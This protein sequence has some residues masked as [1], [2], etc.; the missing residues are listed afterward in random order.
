MADD[1]QQATPGNTGSGNTGGQ[2]QQ[3]D[4]GP[5]ENEMP[6][7]EA[8]DKRIQSGEDRR[9]AETAFGNK[10]GGDSSGG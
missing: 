8:S 6:N 10:E 5:A 9:D 1:Q 4:T 2:Q 7:A 3:D